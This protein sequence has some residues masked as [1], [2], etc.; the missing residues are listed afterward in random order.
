MRRYAIGFFLLCGMFAATAHA[1]DKPVPP[2]SAE[3]CA[4]LAEAGK[5]YLQW[6]TTPPSDMM[7]RG[8]FGADCDWPAHGMAAPVVA[9]PQDGPYYEGLRFGFDQPVYSGDGM[10]ATVVVGVAGNASATRYF[11]TDSVCTTQKKEGRWQRAV[12][13]RHMIT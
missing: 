1:Q 8:S 2:A 11:I 3:D 4:V 6:G 12:C 9:P 13:V 5:A 10:T 7:W